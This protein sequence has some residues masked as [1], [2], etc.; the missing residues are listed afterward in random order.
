MALA[1]NTFQS[2]TIVAKE[3]LMM[4]EN[5]L[6]VAK[7]ISRDWENKLGK[8]GDTL[9]LR[10]PVEF[11]ATKARARS[12]SAIAE[13]G[14]TLSV[15][16]QAHVSFEW[17][18][19]D[20]TDTIERIS[21]RYIE[22]AMSAL[23]NTVDIDVYALY[24][25]VAAQVGVPGTAPADYDVY[26]DARTKLNDAS[27]GL[28]NRYVYVNPAGEGATLKGLQDLFIPDKINKI[29]SDGFLGSLAGFD[30]YMAQNIQVHET[31]VFTTNSTPLVDGATQTG[32]DLLSNGWA[33]AAADLSEGDTFTVAGVNAVNPKTGLS[34]GTLRQF[35][36]TA[37]ISDT[38]GAINIP[39]SPSIIT[40]GAYKTC[41]ASPANDAVITMV[42][43]EDTEYPQN[44]AF[45]KEAF[46]LAMRP[47]EIPSSAV[48]GA[49]E[50]YKD[51]S[52]RVIKAYD[53]TDDK[54]KFSTLPRQAVSSY[55][56]FDEF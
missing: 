29:V 37:A 51:M 21:E 4:F 15:A 19:K 35:V 41:T 20:I 30:F 6:G 53:I 5:N 9:K 56:E 32:A 54:M 17:S 3:S 10:N 2:S 22:P 26:V 8:D 27:V 34:T 45:H 55:N 12:N 16:T 43:T 23:A 33:S 7:M 13:S 11:R 31:G 48:Y 40:T 50:S 47:L 42:G 36:V 28:K 14:P 25:D 18:T 1:S 46:T 49:R 52:A 39:I 38:S 24:V 44:L